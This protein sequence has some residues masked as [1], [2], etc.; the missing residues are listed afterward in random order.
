M[1]ESLSSRTPK[2]WGSAPNPRVFQWY[3]LLGFMAQASLSE[4]L[5]KGRRQQ[6]Y[7]NSSRVPRYQNPQKVVGFCDFLFKPLS[8]RGKGVW[9]KG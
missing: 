3:R 8:W 6:G 1:D 4:P 5:F 7:K 2:T 9:G